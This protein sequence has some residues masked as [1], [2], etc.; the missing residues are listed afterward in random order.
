MLRLE[1]TDWH[2]GITRAQ[3]D[4]VLGRMRRNGWGRDDY[5][6]LLHNCI[7]FCK[8]C[9]CVCLKDGG[10]TWGLCAEKQIFSGNQ[11]EK[12][13]HQFLI[14]SL[15]NDFL[16]FLLFL[17]VMNV[18]DNYQNTYVMCYVLCSMC[19]RE[20]MR[21]EMGNGKIIEL[22]KSAISKIE[23]NEQKDSSIGYAL[24]IIHNPSKMKNQ[25]SILDYL[26]V[27]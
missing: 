2:I 10:L 21:W 14:W 27:E 23:I 17:Q 20:K 22:C 4:R 15:P 16:K 19:N 12:K 8:V 9:I 6:G 5:C 26:Q 3:L 18:G 1:R 24:L 13:K 7:H 11:N 25:Y